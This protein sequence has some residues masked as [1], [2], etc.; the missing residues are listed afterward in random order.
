MDYSKL[1]PQP[2]YSVKGIGLTYKQLLKKAA[3][4]QPKLYKE[5]LKK[6]EY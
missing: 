1:K 3:K 5:Y 4:K 6:S 2:R